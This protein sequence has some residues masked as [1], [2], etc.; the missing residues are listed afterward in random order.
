MKISHT[1]FSN[2]YKKY[3][4]VYH[5][6]DNTLQ[7][8][9]N[10]QYSEYVKDSKSFKNSFTVNQHPVPFLE[11]INQKEKLLMIQQAIEL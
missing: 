8:H 11:E 10:T 4:L 7:S 2:I 3:Y 5:N 1:E 6:N 9:I